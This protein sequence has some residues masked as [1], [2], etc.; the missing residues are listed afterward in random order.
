MKCTMREPT[1]TRIKSHRKVDK[2][3][4]LQMGYV[5]KAGTNIVKKIAIFHITVALAFYSRDLVSV[6]MKN[7]MRV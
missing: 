3:I 1:E 7:I 6:F 4:D 2:V 5:I